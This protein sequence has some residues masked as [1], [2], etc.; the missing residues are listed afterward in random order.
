MKCY[1]NINH[2]VTGEN[3][4]SGLETYDGILERYC[5]F[6]YYGN[7]SL[8]IWFNWIGRNKF[9]NTTREIPIKRSTYESKENK[10]KS[11]R[12]QGEILAQNFINGITYECHVE[13]IPNISPCSLPTLEV[14]CNVVFFSFLNSFLLKLDNFSN[15]IYF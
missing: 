7:P 4:C 10:L 11:I 3:D 8:T 6:D 5:S 1:S 14:E 13:N 15:Y 12:H 2:P 9:N